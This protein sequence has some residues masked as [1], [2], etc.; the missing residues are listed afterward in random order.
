[1]SCHEDSHPESDWRQ[2]AD[3]R[4]GNLPSWWHESM[5]LS[6]T[7]WRGIILV[8]F[9]TL[10]D[11]LLLYWRFADP[12]AVPNIPGVQEG[13]QY[14]ALSI[15]RVI[16]TV[17]C[18]VI[19]ISPTLRNAPLVL[20]ISGIFGCQVVLTL[21]HQDFI[22]ASIICLIYGFSSIE[23]FRLSSQY[24]PR[25]L[26]RKNSL[27]GY[28]SYLDSV[29]FTKS[30]L[31]FIFMCIVS[32]CVVDAL[33]LYFWLINP[34]LAPNLPVFQKLV[35]YPELM[36]SRLTVNIPSLIYLSLPLFRRPSHL[37]FIAGIFYCEGLLDFVYFSFISGNVGYIVGG[38]MASGHLYRSVK[39]QFSP[40]SQD[41]E[42]SE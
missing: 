21:I 18:L 29:I 32:I 34:D 22:S 24:I 28:Y 11:I 37:L 41:E 10:V 17:P 7:E 38:W 4:E 27:N 3:A 35:K 8:A 33:T 31:V 5:P 19:F 23:I 13:M 26:I 30:V 16:A 15:L 42:I 12:D 1:M 39:E 2:Q 6:G 36:I 9:I 40:A 25:Q 14:P 20:S